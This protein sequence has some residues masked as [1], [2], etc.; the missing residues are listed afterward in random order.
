MRE[1]VA[2]AASN[3][4]GGCGLEGEMLAETRLRIAELAEENEAL[5]ARCGS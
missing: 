2:A 3:A 5:Q 4:A 1:S